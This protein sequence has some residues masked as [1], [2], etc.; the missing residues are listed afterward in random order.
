MKLRG[1]FPRILQ[2]YI[3]WNF[4]LTLYCRELQ[5]TPRD[6]EE[7]RQERDNECY[8]SQDELEVPSK[9]SKQPITKQVTF[10][11]SE[12]TSK[13]PISSIGASTSFSW[14]SE[15]LVHLWFSSISRS[16]QKH[17]KR[18]QFVLTHWVM[19]SLLCHLSTTSLVQIERTVNDVMF[20]T[21]KHAYS[22]V[23]WRNQSDSL[24]M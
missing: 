10:D 2:S 17:H 1:N 15:N 5:T 12:L 9:G 11:S 13:T 24:S 8:E 16:L 22:K 3:P 18:D 19:W 4:S 21:V 14:C 6:Q 20:Y 7:P 23:M